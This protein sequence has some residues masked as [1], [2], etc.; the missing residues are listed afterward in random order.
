[1]KV[2]LL[3]DV[4]DL[5]QKGDLVDAKTGYARNYL[6]P[7]GLAVEG[8]KE[9]MKKWEADQKSKDEK[10]KA[11][12]EAALK[13]KEE[14]EKL[15]IQLKAKGGEGGRLFGSITSKDIADALKKQGKIEIDRRK[16]EL[17]DN[18]KSGGITVVDVRV[19]PEITAQ[20]KVNVDIEQ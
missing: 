4:K 19:Y 9:N 16:I 18:I 1:M 3:E 14:I 15:T 6:L 8:T 5:G 2:I 13:L 10:R 12:E 7:R 11:E 20:L 17:S